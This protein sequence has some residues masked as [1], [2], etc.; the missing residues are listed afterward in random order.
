MQPKLYFQNNHTTSSGVASNRTMLGSE[1][2]SSASSSDNRTT[3][4]NLSNRLTLRHRFHR[5]GRTLSADFQM[6]HTNHAADRAQQSL[7]RFTAP[8]SLATIDETSGSNGTTNSL[9]SRFAYTEP[10][11]GH[12]QA[13][14]TYNPSITH[15]S[16]D[17]RT[18]AYDSLTGSY[19]ALDPLQSNSFANQHHVQNGGAAVQYKHGTWRWLTQVS[20]QSTLLRSD[21]SFPFSGFV[22]HTFYDLLPSMTLTG[23]S[24]NKRNVRL[25]WVTASNVPHVSQLQ[26]VVDNSNPLSLSTGNPDLRETHTN[27]IT[28]RVSEADPLRSKSRFLFANVVRSTNPISNYTY[29]AP[30]DT[31]VTGVHLARG[32]QLTHPVNLDVSWASNLFLAYSWP[33]KWM[34]SIFTLNGGGS[35]SETPTKLD[36]EINRNRTTAARFGATIASNISEDFDFTVSYQGSYN[37]SRNTLSANNTGDY[38]AHTLGLRLSTVM[39][40]GIVMREEV[41]NV[42]QNNASVV[43]GQNQVLW[44]TTLGKKFMKDEKSELRVTITDVLH[45]DRSVGRSITP[46]YVQDS[47][48]LALGTFMQAVFT[49]SFR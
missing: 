22:S 1:V 35:F 2:S 34:K 28:L 16:S 27:T 33:A 20:Y 43:F 29:T 21:Q 31:V 10:L 49:Y 23:T 48:D 14:L 24:A 37:L 8:E 7:N 40:S 45:Q 39:R 11:W 13:Q 47:R 32:T 38:Y 6:G 42:L 18:F 3:G 9:V 15:S 44:N 5:R 36:Q 46:T 26:P 17:A 41:S 25:T 4:N 12:W 30:V 19:S